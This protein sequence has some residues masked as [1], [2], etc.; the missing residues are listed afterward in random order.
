MRKMA[1]NQ[2][3]REGEG[4]DYGKGQLYTQMDNDEWL[5]TGGF[6]PQSMDSEL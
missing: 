3:W 2:R 6:P 4:I 5:M 1:L